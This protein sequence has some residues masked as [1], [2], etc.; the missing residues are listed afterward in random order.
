MSTDSISNDAKEAELLRRSFEQ[1]QS[2]FDRFSTD[3]YDALF[4]RAPE[5]RSLFRDDLAGQGMK[6]MTT[7][8][9]VILNTLDGAADTD[10]LAELGGHH[11]KL[12]VTAESFAPMEEALIDTLKDTLGDRF[13]AAHEAAWR[14]AYADI[15]ATMIRTGGIA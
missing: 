15:A 5:L 3:F 2:D 14:K 7:L 4:R 6:F 11:A 12:G 1:V 9:E 13:T 8:R 10:R